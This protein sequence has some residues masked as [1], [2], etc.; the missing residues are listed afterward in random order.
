MITIAL[1]IVVMMR[2]VIIMD[3]TIVVVMECLLYGKGKWHT[4]MAGGQSDEE[5]SD[6]SLRFSY[7]NIQPLKLKM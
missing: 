7:T 6:R 5:H 4:L 3:V 2:V 1:V